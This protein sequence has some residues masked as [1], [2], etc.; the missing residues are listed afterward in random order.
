MAQQ[1]WIAGDNGYTFAGVISGDE[2][3]VENYDDLVS[4][5]DG[6]IVEVNS[7]PDKIIGKLTSLLYELGKDYFDRVG[8]LE[9]KLEQLKKAYNR[10]EHVNAV[11][12]QD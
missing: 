5:M 7:N 2:P 9:Y 11:V 3:D 10:H 4:Y 6:M 1:K 8:E 12:V